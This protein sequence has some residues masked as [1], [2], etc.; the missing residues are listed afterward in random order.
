MKGTHKLMT[1]LLLA[2]VVC[3]SAIAIAPQPVYADSATIVASKDAEIAESDPD[4]NWGDHYEMYVGDYDGGLRAL[5]Q[6][7]VNWGS[8]IPSGAIIT[9]ATLRLYYTGYVQTGF[10]PV[11]RTLYAQRLRRLDWVEMQATWNHYKSGSAWGTAGAASTTSDYTTSGQASANVPSSA[12][13]WLEWD[14]LSQVQWAQSYGTNVGFRIVDSSEV[15]KYYARFA[16]RDSLNSAQRPRLVITYTLPSAPTVTTDYSDNV[17]VS[18][19]RLH[20]TVTD[21]GGATVT[22]RGFQYGKSQTPTWDTYETGSYGTGSY[23]RTI[24]GLDDDTI[25]YYRA[26]AQNS[27]GTN[28]GSWLSFRTEEQLYVPTVT[29]DSATAITDTTATLEGTVSSTGGATVTE[30]GFEYGLTQT[31]TWTVDESGSYGT[32]SYALG[33]SSLSGG[34]TYWYRAY[35]ENVQGTGYGIWRSFTTLEEPTVQTVEQSNV[36]MT[37]ARLNAHVTEDGGEAVTIRFGWGLTSEATIEA[38]DNYGTVSGTWSKGQNVYL[39]V[40]SLSQ[41]TLYYFRAEAI[42]SIGNHLGAELSFTTEAGVADVSNFKAIPHSDRE[43]GLSVSL[44]WT[45]ASGSSITVIRYSTLGYPA[46]STDGTALYG[47]TGSSFV[48]TGV[49]GGTTYY[50][51]AWGQSGT[52]ESATAAEVLVTTLPAVTIPDTFKSPT[53]WARMF[54]PPDHTRMA[55][56][57]IIYDGINNMADVFHMPRGVAWMILAIAIS[58]VLAIAVYLRTRRS[59]LVGGLALVFGMLFGWLLWLLPFWLPLMVIIL[60]VV[61][62]VSQREMRY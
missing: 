18:G 17:G 56:L 14:V 33:I 45:K 8:T 40:D 3:I 2:V 60:L 16:T 46:S 58:A 22:K 53:P 26:Y 12:G 9:G 20:G 27:V 19:A 54:A 50:Y 23:S 21:T 49:E 30:R 4:S 51:A 11:G 47:G 48:H 52:D 31:G 28:Y 59:L 41:D 61:L 42:N 43:E 32:G 62:T 29:T 57:G 44:S 5:V 38:Y 55:N 35:A 37:T 25:Y 24:S 10:D 6:F 15:H 36:G 13:T 1:R 39:D 34:T 7:T